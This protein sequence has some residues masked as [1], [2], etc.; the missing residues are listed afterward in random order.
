MSSTPE[1]SDV[2]RSAKRL[3]WAVLITAVIMAIFY[4][5]ARFDLIPGRVHVEHYAHGLAAGPAWLIADGASL[6]LIGALVHLVLML[7][8]IARGEL[9]SSP[10]IRHFRGFALWLLLMALFRWFA[11]M[12]AQFVQG[13]PDGV[14]ELHMSFDFDEIMMVGMTL[15][16]FLLARLLERARRLDEEVREFV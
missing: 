15:L 13:R 11:P 1:T 14:H 7:G 10:V 5:I 6:L 3:R 2:T 4:A 16:L 9:F 8:R 12:A